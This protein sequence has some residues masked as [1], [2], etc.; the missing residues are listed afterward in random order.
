M[1]NAMRGKIA[2]EQAR[3]LDLLAEA[4]ERAQSRKAK[5][6]EIYGPVTEAL[7]VAH[8]ALGRALRYFG[9]DG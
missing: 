8:D 9:P 4:D 3:V 5:A 2:A 7:Q 6:R 1:S